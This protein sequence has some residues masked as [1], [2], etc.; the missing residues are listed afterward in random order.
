MSLDLALSGLTVRGCNVPLLSIR[1]RLPMVAA[2]PSCVPAPGTCTVTPIVTEVDVELL[3]MT[4]VTVVGML[5]P[6][7]FVAI[8]GEDAS[9]LTDCKIAIA[10][11]NRDERFSMYALAQEYDYPPN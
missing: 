5:V 8:T 3:I 9:R 4:R 11:K 6:G 10:N 1:K 7:M 2:H